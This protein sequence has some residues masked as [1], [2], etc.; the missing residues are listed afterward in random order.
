MAAASCESKRSSAYSDDLRW[1]IVWQ[2]E[3]LQFTISQIAVNLCV[4]ESTVRRR[5]ETSGEVAK[6]EYPS[7][8]CSRK[9]TEPVQFYIMNLVLEKPGIYLSEIT[10]ELET[11]LGVD[12]SESAVCKFLKK[13][14]FSRQALCTYALQRDEDMRKR[15]VRDVSLY[16][17]E[18]IL[19]ID[20]TGSDRRDSLRKHGY[21][22][23]GQGAVKGSLLVRGEHVTAI[24]AMSFYSFVCK[25]LLS[26]LMPFEGSNPNSVV[27]LD[28]IA[29]FITCR[30]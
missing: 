26:K 27:I 14:G 29:P 3:A 28:N 11:V 10:S 2:R 15:F 8:A 22:L 12:V 23:R 16:P 20:E 1:R 5:F 17:R 19:F 6:S 18:T 25:S 21:S 4:S 30:K 7:E 13:A 9:I 24:A